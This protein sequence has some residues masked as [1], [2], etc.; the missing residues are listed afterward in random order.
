[1]GHRSHLIVVP[2]LGD[3]Q[4]ALNPNTSLSFR[5]SIT[6]RLAYTCLLA[7]STGLYISIG[8]I[9]WFRQVDWPC[10]LVYTC[11]INMVGRLGN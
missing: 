1:M 10:R 7:M 2:P 11:E 8:F 6:E 9:S 3:F 5:N 4:F